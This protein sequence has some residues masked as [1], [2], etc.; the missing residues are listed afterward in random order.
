MVAFWMPFGSRDVP[1]P[2]LVS[3]SSFMFFWSVTGVKNS[4]HMDTKSVH[5]TTFWRFF[6][7]VFLGAQFSHM[8]QFRVP[9]G[10]QIGMFFC[11]LEI[12]F[13]G[14]ISR[15]DL[16]SIC[17]SIF[18]IFDVFGHPFGECFGTNM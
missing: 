16:V 5:V 14:M 18:E 10:V 2:I 11:T 15:L 12:L 9:F 8:L 1:G 3:L 13:A 4:P 17:S 6:F 7:V